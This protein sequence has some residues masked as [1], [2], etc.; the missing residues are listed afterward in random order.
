MAKQVFVP[1]TVGDA[2]AR[3]AESERTGETLAF[4]G[5]GTNLGIGAV[6]DRIDL[7]IRTGNLNRVVEHAPSDQI[8]AVEAGVTLARVQEVVGAHAQRLAIDPPLPDRATIGGIVAANAFG[9]LRARYGSVRDLIIGISIIRADG[10]I[11]RGGG[12]VV[13]NVA[14]FDLP[15]LMVGSLGTLGMIATATFRLHPLPEISE[16]L[17]V[18]HR[19]ASAVRSLIAEMKQAQLEVSAVAAIAEGNGFD[20]AVRF[21]GFRAGVVAQRD[22]LSGQLRAGGGC[23]ILDADGAQRLWLRHDAIRAGGPLQLKIAALP[24]AIEMVSSSVV[25]PLLGAMTGAGFVWYPMSGIGFITGT[26]ADDERIAAVIRKSRDMLV[27][28]RGSLTIEAAPV[29]VRRLVN[30]WGD[31]G[32]DALSVMQATKQKF[33]PGRRLAPGRFVGGI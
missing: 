16:T 26:P 30:M 3:I 13:K 2:A 10:V 4:I 6:P 7:I 32:G 5:G 17:L 18:S 33:D 8:I 24:S 19:S 14:G 31:V 27:K 12:K 29:A 11:A 25:P 21:E 1:D 20:V 15:K 22:R 28:A 23:D 9:P